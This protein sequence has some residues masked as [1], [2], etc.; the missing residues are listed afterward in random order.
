[1]K[2]V[3]SIVIALLFFLLLFVWGTR[4][5]VWLIFTAFWPSFHTVALGFFLILLLLLWRFPQQVESLYKRVVSIRY[6]I[7]PLIAF[8]ASSLIVYFVFQ[9]IPHVIDASHFVWMTRLMEQGQLSIPADALYEY[10]RNTFNLLHN[11]RYFSLFL[12]GFS[13]FL[14]PFSFFGILPLSG[15]LFFAVTIYLIGKIADKLTNDSSVSF[16]AMVLVLFSSFYLFMSASFMTHTFNTML[17]LGALYLLLRSMKWKNLLFAGLLLAI[18]LFIRPQN[19]VFSYIPFVAWIV[20]KNRNKIASFTLFTLPFILVGFGVMFYNFHFTGEFLKFPQ[21]IYF[22][23]REPL[24]HCHRLGI[25]KGCPNTEGIYLPDGGLTWS[26]AFW[27]AYTRLTLLLFNVTTHPYILLFI[28]LGYFLKAKRFLFIAALFFSYF[29]GYFFFYLPGN[30]FG[31][32][33][34]TEVVLLLL[35]PAAYGFIWT[36]RHINFVGKSAVIA[37]QLSVFVLFSYTIMPALTKSYSERFWRTDRVVEHFIEDMKIK[38]SV[39]FIPPYYAATFLNLMENPPHDRHGNL[40][41]LDRDREN[42]YAAAWYIE[43][44]GYDSA[45]VFDYYP[46]SKSLLLSEELID[47]TPEQ[48][49]IEFEDKRLPLT[50]VPDYGVTY[51]M[52]ETDDKRFFPVKHLDDTLSLSNGSAFAMHFR[53]ITEKSYYDFTYPLLIEGLYDISMRYL[54]TECAGDFSFEVNGEKVADFSSGPGRQRGTTLDM[55]VK[56]RHGVNNF[57]I[58]AHSENSCLVLDFIKISVHYDPPLQSNE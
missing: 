1:M 48:V 11:G 32:R 44:G 27:V 31:P 2:R 46:E 57:K 49:Y 4:G 36:V 38:N 54:I 55:Q 26:Y 17:T 34:F 22:M 53:K 29:V 7:L 12:P 24:A 9:G 25:G 45:F 8:I 23:I 10:Y 5:R 43:K 50:G 41:L 20:I 37:L 13:F 6:F 47:L 33:Y 21:D 58:A 42:R 39:L 40:I 52:S 3:G 56:L 16:L 14:L 15:P 30:L 35:I 19:A 18:L 51:A 28:S